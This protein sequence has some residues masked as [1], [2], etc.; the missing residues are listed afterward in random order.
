M[1]GVVAG[2]ESRL[3]GRGDLPDRLRGTVVPCAAISDRAVIGRS[4]AVAG[5]SSQARGHSSA[6]S[7]LIGANGCQL[8]IRLRFPDREP[9]GGRGFR[10]LRLL[11]ALAFGAVAQWPSSDRPSSLAGL[12]RDHGD[13][14]AQC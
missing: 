6:T 9:S 7:A 14:D 8:C 4:P 10:C 1:E 12:L 5:R 11:M 13:S 2:V 3:E